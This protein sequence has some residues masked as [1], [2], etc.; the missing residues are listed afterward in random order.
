[1]DP[2]PLMEVGSDA[3]N[4]RAVFSSAQCTIGCPEHI[5]AREIVALPP[6]FARSNLALTLHPPAGMPSA[7]PVRLGPAREHRPS[8]SFLRRAGP[9]VFARLVATAITFSIPLVLARQLS[10]TDYGTYKQLFLLAMTLQAVLPFGMA[11]SLYFFLPRADDR[12]PYLVQSHLFL[13]VGGIVGAMLL[14][15]FSEPLS[16]AFSNP[17]IQDYRTLIAP[18][19]VCAIGSYALEMSLTAQG[20]TRES[21]I[22]YIASDTLR[23]IALIAPV[24]LGWGLR[25]SLIGITAVS[26]ARLAFLWALTAFSFQGKWWDTR[27]FLRQL[28]YAAPFGAAMVLNQPQ[29]VAHQYAVSSVVAPTLFAI[30]AVGCFQIPLV[31]LL[32]QPTSEILMVRIAEL[33]RGGRLQ[34]CVCAFREAASKLAYLF[35]PLVSFLWVTAPEF[36]GALFG[37]RFLAA[38][39]IFR[40]SLLGVI[41][42]TLPMDG[43]LRARNDTRY[44]FWS[45]FFKALVTVPLV[46][47]TVRQWGMIGGISAWAIAELFG[48]LT[49]FLRI[50]RALSAGA[51]RLGFADVL[52]GAS[53]AKAAAASAT[54]ALFLLALQSRLST[55]HPSWANDLVARAIPMGLLALAFGGAY[56]LALRLLGIRPVRAFAEFRGGGPQ[57]TIAANE[58]LPETG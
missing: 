12:K 29:Q 25:G 19:V 16:R 22:S 32:Y 41:L 47:F 37:P 4:G 13:L 6:D 2:I 26:A 42:P 52:P 21:A 53:L 11:Q 34:E 17:G 3:D 35:F 51:T 33:E 55:F 58:S 20:K 9:L 8:G 43:V 45:Y 54:A 1:M 24:L 28:S 30:Y 7:T 48:K 10:L 50:P 23:A 36:I 27:A 15:V 56:L 40:V 31:D 38:V 5:E 46:Y 44:L 18:Y 57:A 49:L 39:P 14:L